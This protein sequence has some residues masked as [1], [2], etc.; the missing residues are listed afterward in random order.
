MITQSSDEKMK[1]YQEN[2]PLFL[3]K[4]NAALDEQGHTN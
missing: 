4:K 3:S 1:A 2:I